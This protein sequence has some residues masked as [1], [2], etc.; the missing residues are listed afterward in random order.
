MLKS[1]DGYDHSS[2]ALYAFSYAAFA[3]DLIY[4]WDGWTEKDRENIEQT[5]RFYMEYIDAEICSGEASN[6]LLAEIAGAVYS[7]AVLGDKERKERF[8]YGPGG[9]A[10]ELAKGVLDDGWWYE[11]SIGY[12]LMCAGLMSELSVAA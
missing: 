1:I 6:W 4:D 3:Y 12:N 2:D 8:L 7:A 10:D 9:A 11:A 5:M